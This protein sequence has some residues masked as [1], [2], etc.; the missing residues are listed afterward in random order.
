M[1]D[2][3]KRLGIQKT[4]DKTD[5]EINAIGL[6]NLETFNILV[7]K[8]EEE[9]DRIKVPKLGRW[10]RAPKLGLIGHTM[11]FGYGLKVWHKPGPFKYNAKHP[12]L[13]EALVNL[14]NF[15]APTGW[16]Y[17]AITLNKNMIANKHTDSKNTGRSLIIGFGQYSDGLLRIWTSD[18]TFIDHDIKNAPLMFN[19]SILAHEGL[20]FNGTRYSIVL[21]KQ[22]VNVER[23][24][25]L[26]GTP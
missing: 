17:D 22:N 11:T 3:V 7:K 26:V 21:H 8:V 6:K 15:I 16:T 9:A 23:D 5:T 10:N 13:F 19:G 14:G 25:Q 1:S 4:F 2:A 24:R 20:P 12:E 18:N